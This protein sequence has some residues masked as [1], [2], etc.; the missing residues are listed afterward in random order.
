MSFEI[1]ASGFT[2]DANGTYSMIETDHWSNGI[3]FIYH[4]SWYWYLTPSDYKYHEPNAVA[5]KEYIVGDSTG[6]TPI[7]S[8]NGIDG[9]PDGIVSNGECS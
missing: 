9:N 2:A 5:R 6:S 1:C 4:D 8:Y 7:G 3:Y